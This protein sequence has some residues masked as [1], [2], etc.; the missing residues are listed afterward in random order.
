VPRRRS[1]RD[2][3]KPVPLAL[4]HADIERL[5]D[6]IETAALG[7]TETQVAVLSERLWQ[8]RVRLPE[9][10]TRRLIEGRTRTPG[11]AFDLL[12]GFA[13]PD[14]LSGHLRRIA[15][16][17][18][19]PDIVRFGAQ[20]RAGW[21]E[22]TDNRHRLF[23]LETLADSDQTLLEAIRQGSSTWPP[24][25]QVLE[26]VLGYLAALPVERR[27]AVVGRAIDELES[28]ATWLLRALLHADDSATQLLA[29]KALL[30][31]R[32]RGALGPTER[33]A[34][35]TQDAQ[36]R[37][38]ATAA[39]RRLRLEPVDRGDAVAASPLPTFQRALVSQVDGDGG[40]VIL[41]MR[42]W[43]EVVWLFAD[44]F[45]NDHW[46][47][48]QVFGSCRATPDQVEE[49][50]EDLAEGDI[51]L[52][53]VDLAAVRG[54]LDAAIGVNAA[55]RH[56]VPPAFELW[57]PLLHDSYP[58]RDEPVILP[59][60]DD[61]PYA[62][63]Q[64]LVRSSAELAAHPWFDSWRFDPA[65]T[66]AAMIRT[67]P[68]ARA[69]QLTSR[70]FGSLIERLVDGPTRDV[71]RARLR[72]QAWLLD[73]DGDEQAR[74]LALATAAHLATAG[75]AELAG[76]PFLRAIVERSLLDVIEAVRGRDDN[77]GAGEV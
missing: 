29:L 36:L 21:P 61:A 52:V 70:Q 66:A 54:I 12:V 6:E 19:V 68:P 56:A 69:G 58:P 77:G 55:S 33:L 32:G 39:A 59:E 72:R 46:G 75:P 43:T 4:T 71:F 50:L 15:D 18:G 74:E 3:R 67:P 57:E 14:R 2:K 16:N 42:Q 10:L 34:R 17:R 22:W 1:R 25:G 49:M 44:V 73:K 41:V 11:L 30:G 64:D 51:H 26:E 47:V 60:L 24:D 65:R 63:R 76:Q 7:G 35:T 5:L 31:A 9:L 28:E 27:R 37:V 23:F 20:R 8:A 13:R 38:E 62:G 45:H 53:E 40:Q 48:K